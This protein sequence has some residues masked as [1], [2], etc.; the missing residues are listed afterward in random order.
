MLLMVK[1]IH[2]E[3]RVFIR[4]YHYQSDP[5]LG[6]GSVVIRIIPFNCNAWTTVLSL[7]WDLK[8]E[9]SVKQPRYGRVHNRKY[10]QIGGFR[11]TGL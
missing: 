3:T 11:N 7:S 1:H 8:T 10:S 5:E 2:M 6:P 4:Q 9:Y